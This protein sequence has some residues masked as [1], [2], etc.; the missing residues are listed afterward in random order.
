[1]TRLKEWLEISTDGFAQRQADRKPEHLLKEVI[2]NALDAT[3]GIANATVNITVRPAKVQRKNCVEI[4]VED[5]GP[6]I[7]N[8]SDLR[9]VFCTS[10]TDSFLL[11]GRL[12]QGV[13]E[14]L[15]LC[16]HADVYSRN[17]RIRFLVEKGE[18]VCDVDT[19]PAAKGING[20]V[21]SMWLPWE[22]KDIPR[23]EQYVR[24]LIAPAGTTITIN[25]LEI[26]RRPSEFTI[27]VELKTE[28]FGEGKW[29]RRE[30]PGTVHLVPLAF[31]GET[32]MIFE[33]GIPIQELDWTQPFHINVQMRVPMNPRRDAVAAGYLKDVY[34]QVLPVLM[35]KIEPQDLRDEWVSQAIEE[36]EPDLR[37]E[38]VTTAF[39]ADAVRSVPTL[40]KH[41]W[42]SDAREIGYKPIDTKLLPKGLREAAQEVLPTSREVEIQRR[43]TVAVAARESLTQD[44]DGPLKAFVAWL[45]GQLVGFTVDVRIT[46]TLII[47]GSDATAAWSPG[48]ILTLNNEQR[49]SWADPLAPGF[50]GLLCHEVAHEAAPHHGDNF[51][52]EV[53]RMAGKLA[54]LC[55]DRTEEV[56]SRYAIFKEAI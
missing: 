33:M 4:V 21:V 17:H 14:I 43:D 53:E 50:L 7:T 45:A 29:I 35:P 49:G 51:R 12:G 22:Q 8:P 23:L 54:R 1:M 48:G 38:V 42:D 13:K 10:K 32:P 20:T 41:D 18:R 34:R 15:C 39:G 47:N 28:L 31:P 3:E 56:R 25:G 24:G 26:P 16:L 52:R 36:A 37:K 2:Q 30:R 5:N 11:R 46:K 9:T 27:D 44:Q 6:G 55:L 19:F 40:G